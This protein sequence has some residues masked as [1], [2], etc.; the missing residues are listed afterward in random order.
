MVRVLCVMSILLW[1]AV[2]ANATEAEARNEDVPKGPS[3]PPPSQVGGKPQN[4]QDQQRPST[5][6]VS[7]GNTKPA[8]SGG[9]G[10][11]AGGKG[12]AP[13]K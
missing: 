3:A 8:P 10:A 9:G 4:S 5:G 13:G 12:V 7:G 2:A 1:V 6:S 11:G